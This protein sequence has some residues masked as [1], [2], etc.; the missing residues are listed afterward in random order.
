MTAANLHSDDRE[1]PCPAPLVTTL[2][3]NSNEF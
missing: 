3:E 2:L 1:V